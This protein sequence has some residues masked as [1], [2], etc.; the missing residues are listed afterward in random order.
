MIASRTLSLAVALALASFGAQADSFTGPQSSQTPYVVPT[1]TGWEVTSLVTVGDSA[2]ASPYVMVGI[3]DGMGAVAGKF[4]ENGTYV[5]DKAFM[6]VFLN[7]EIR[8]GLGVP[9]AHGADGAFVSQWTVH[10]NSLQMKGG[11]D[12]IRRVLTWQGGTFADTTGLTAFNRFCSGDLP[13]LTGV[14][15]PAKPARASTA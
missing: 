10:L 7:H 12:L 5:A 8:P 13:R 3:P 2:K 15:Q 6:T 14:L 9:R 11:E 4:A 1:A